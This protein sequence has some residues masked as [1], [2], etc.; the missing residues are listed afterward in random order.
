M[1][2]SS[3]NPC[4][5]ITD[6]LQAIGTVG[7]VII[8]LFFFFWER[9]R[10]WYKKPRLKISLQ[11]R[12]PDCHFLVTNL[13]AKRNG[14]I[15]NPK[16]YYFR[17]TV[18]NNG[19]SSAKDLEAIVSKMELK[20]GHSWET[21]PQFLSTSLKWTHISEQYLPMILSKTEK[22]LDLGH[23]IDPAF[24]NDF[25]EEQ[26]LSLNNIADTHAL[27]HFETFM[28]PSNG[29]NNIPP[30]EYKFKITVGATNCP[31]I[32]STIHL[33]FTGKWNN[34]EDLMLPKE[35]NLAIE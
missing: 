7:A 27:F 24:R 18:S 20:S 14:K 13:E 4:A 28:Q 33:L 22:K 31:P 16:A 10:E 23:I 12:P 9:I 1:T 25:R 8:A 2:I 6:W 3:V 35:I 30:G 34:Q 15:I 29:Y 21:Y 11:F 19:R 5:N 17:L 26:N 32:S